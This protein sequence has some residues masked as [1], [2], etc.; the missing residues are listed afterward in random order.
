L[1][2]TKPGTWQRTSPFAVLFFFGKLLKTVTQNAWQSLAPFAAFVYAYEG[3]LVTRIGLGVAAFFAFATIASVLNYWFFRFQ[4]NEDSIL[5]RQGVLK[6]KQID[7]KFDRI[8]GINTQQNV[9]FRYF[10][11][12]TVNFDTAGSSGDEG[13]LPAVTRDFAESLR[14]RIGRP[15]GRAPATSDGISDEF[16]PEALLTLGWR[17]MVRIGLADRRVYVVLAAVGSLTERLLDGAYRAGVGYIEDAAGNAFDVSFAAGISLF[18]A[19]VAGLMLLLAI[20]SI[21]AA[22]LRW[23]NFELILDGDALRSHGGLLTRHEVSINLGKIQTLRLEQSIVMRWLNCYRL[24]AQQAR[25][26]HKQSKRKDFIVP[27]LNAE[28]ADHLREL[29]LAPE[30]D[31]LI[32]IPTSSHFRPISQYYMRSRVL[33]IGL[34]PSVA[35]T[36]FFW[37]VFGAISLLLMA[38]LPVS[39]LLAYNSWR[40]AG[41]LCSADGLVRRSGVLGYRSVAL[42]YRKVQ[43]VSV[44]QSRYQRS[45]GLA[46]LRVYMASGSVRIPYIEHDAAKRLRDYILYKIESSQQAWH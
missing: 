7:I 30:G 1:K 28:L 14:Q 24:T 19:F 46:S 27:V 26:S 4:L 38:W 8:Q 31:E 44:T 35:G 41:Y 6:K 45:K 20:V 3:E 11:L 13:S 40:R 18:G 39:I 16:N 33:F 22:I 5:I 25:S 17:D 37:Q 15:P 10:G 43:R 23:H 32:Q 34:M 29:L 42:L 21:G 12:V 9:L 36:I 2:L